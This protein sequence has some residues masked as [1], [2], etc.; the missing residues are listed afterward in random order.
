MKEKTVHP[1]IALY[2]MVQTLGFRLDPTKISNRMY[3][4]LRYIDRASRM[5]WK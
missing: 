5:E 4:Q 1:A 2:N 3:L